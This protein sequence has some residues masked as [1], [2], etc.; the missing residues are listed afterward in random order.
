MRSRQPR[1]G[2]THQSKNAPLFEFVI[3]YKSEAYYRCQNCRRAE[4]PG[5]CR[6][7]TCFCGDDTFEGKVYD[8]RDYAGRQEGKGLHPVPALRGNTLFVGPFPCTFQRIVSRQFNGEPHRAAI[9]KTRQCHEGGTENVSD[10]RLLHDQDPF[11]S[12][13]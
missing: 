11:R 9:E 8:K 2:V 13:R 1:T 10:I 7:E 12:D 6:L 5:V 3:Q 4:Y